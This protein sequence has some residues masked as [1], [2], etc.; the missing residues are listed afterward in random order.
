M[1]FFP[2]NSW[3]RLHR[4]FWCFVFIEEGIS[5]TTFLGK[6]YSNPNEDEP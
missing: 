1:Y 3:N 4:P 5:K 6:Y 2:H